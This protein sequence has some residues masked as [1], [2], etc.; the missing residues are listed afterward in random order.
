MVCGA[1]RVLVALLLAAA[2]GPDRASKPPGDPGATE[3]VGAVTLKY[4]PAKLTT[5]A[6]VEITTNGGGRYVETTANLTA[7]LQLS[8]EGDALVVAWS[9]EEVEDLVLQGT[10][11][12][13]DVDLGDELTRH[14]KGAWVIDAHGVEDLAATEAHPK[15]AA[16]R[17]LLAAETARLAEAR[18]AGAELDPDPAATLLELFPPLLVPPRLPVAALAL[19]KTHEEKTTTELELPAFRLVLPIDTTTKT[20]L[21]GVDT[22]GSSRIAELQLDVMRY[23]GLDVEEQGTVELEEHVEG[24]VLFDLDHGVLVRVELTSTQ[25][26]TAG[27]RSG[28]TTTLVRAEF[29]PI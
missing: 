15:N 11:R 19:G 4:R 21:M 23:G 10:I 14:G 24:T 25:S 7:S 9:I 12:K 5:R 26:F 8:A 18:D 22:S 27:E 16:R 2:C 28:D 3:A 6:A 17:D 1:G 13:G 29:V 20:T